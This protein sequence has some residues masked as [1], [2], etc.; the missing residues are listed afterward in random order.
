M[1]GLIIASLVF[2]LKSLIIN[3]VLFSCCSIFNKSFN[4]S[5]NK[6]GG[7]SGRQYIGI[8]ITFPLV[9]CSSSEISTATLD[10][11]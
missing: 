1:L 9:F 11:K 10:L 2:I 6:M 7:T 8:I 4:F 5:L 3:I